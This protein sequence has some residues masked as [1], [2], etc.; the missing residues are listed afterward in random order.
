[1]LRREVA[2]QKAIRQVGNPGISGITRSSLW[3]SWKE[4][5]KQLK[6]AP[7]RDV[8]DFLEYDIDPEVWISRLLRRLSSEEY[9]PE[10]PVRYTLAKAKGFDRVITV[11]AVPDLVLYRTIVDHL[12]RKA[13]TQQ[14]RH[15]YFSQSTLSKAVDAAEKAAVLE[16]EGGGAEDETPYPTAARNTFLEWLKYDQYRKLLIFK[17]VYPYIVV[18]DI[19]NFFDSVLYGRIEESLYGIPAPPR[20][21]SLLFLLLESFSLREAFTPVQRIGLPVD[22]CD[23]SRVLAHMILFPHDRRMVKRVGDDA[24]VRWMDDQN[25]GVQSKAE[26]MRVLGAVCE[27]LRKLHLTPNSSKSTILSLSRAKRYFHFA[28]NSAL[29]A[30]EALPHD[31]SKQRTMLRRSVRRE[32][33]VARQLEGEGEWQKILK[34]F[35]R[36]AARSRSKLLVRRAR[37]DVKEMPGLVERI[38]DYLRYVS[39]VNT[40]ISFVETLLADEEQI[41]PDVNYQLIESLLKLSPERSAALRLS[42][43]GLELLKMTVEFPGA[44]EARALAPLLILRYGDGR[45]VR[46]LF[47]HLKRHGETL[48]QDVTRALCAVVGGC[49]RNGFRTVQDVASTLLRNHLSEFVK[50]IVR[51]R[52]FKTVPGRFK[53]RVKLRR[54][55]I[56]GAPFVDMRAILA[57]RI[58]G[59]SEHKA[60]RDWLAVTKVTQQA[61]RISPFEIGLL[62]KLWPARDHAK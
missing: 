61:A 43:F 53:D 42:H 14:V 34:R 19:T 22:P 35:Y 50:L 52:E 28:A 37:A 4:V 1:M 40:A 8:L 11:P 9:S 60:V 10:R 13:K 44:A 54:D 33:A 45:S 12:Y 2:A 26:G 23:C 5:R 49:K 16:M 24:Y 38:T 57:A 3:S 41:Y 27:S 17:R 51:V 39:D 6:R 25:I 31:T 29:D 36:Q 56:T 47:T 59:L 20:L 18:T 55:S 30:L 7:R 21:V 32:W 58:L 46:G 62:E 48:P 15:A